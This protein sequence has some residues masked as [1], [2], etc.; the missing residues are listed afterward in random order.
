MRFTGYP[1]GGVYGRSLVHWSDELQLSFVD[2]GLH[3]LIPLTLERCN[4]CGARPAIF[5][6]RRL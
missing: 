4:M 5:A 1:P 6:A 2:N 3:T